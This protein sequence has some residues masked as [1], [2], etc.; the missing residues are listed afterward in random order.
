MGGAL[1]PRTPEALCS[2]SQATRQE[3]DAPSSPSLPPL[4]GPCRIPGSLKS[5][6]AKDPPVLFTYPRGL[7]GRGGKNI[8]THLTT[9]QTSG[10]TL[11]PVGERP[12]LNWMARLPWGA[13]WGTSKEGQEGG[14]Q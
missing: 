14:S 12:L 13:P 1:G 6:S 8:H 5:V 7:R 9:F 10:T 2:V 3:E 4:H 11:R